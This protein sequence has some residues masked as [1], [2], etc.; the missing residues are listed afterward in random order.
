M[1][2]VGLYSEKE[3]WLWQSSECQL[4]LLSLIQLRLEQTSV[5]M[6]RT[7]LFSSLADPGDGTGTGGG[8]RTPDLNFSG[9]RNKPCNRET[10]KNT[11]NQSMYI[12]HQSD[13]PSIYVQQQPQQ[14]H[15]RVQNNTGIYL[16]TMP[17]ANSHFTWSCV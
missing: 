12:Q 3:P 17:C 11:A 7:P 2:I 16:Q 14:Q 6:V 4:L 10:R 13:P 1:W 5:G 8:L 15:H 9:T